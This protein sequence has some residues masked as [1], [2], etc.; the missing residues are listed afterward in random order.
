VFLALLCLPARPTSSSTVMKLTLSQLVKKSE[1]IVIG[2]VVAQDFQVKGNL[3]F[4]RNTVQ[5]ENALSGDPADTIDVVTL[6]G[7]RGDGI[8]LFV[9]GEASFAPGERFIAFLIRQDGTWRVLGMAQGK[10]RIEEDEASGCPMVLP[11]DPVH[12]VSMKSGK[13]V[14][15]RP[16]MTEAVP[17]DA[18]LGDLLLEKDGHG[19]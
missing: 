11:P 17:L 4:T 10:M 12:V 18:F 14:K 7:K 6:G 1:A 2:T 19:H 9:F 15:D 8:S 16:F 5:V 3:V 13:L